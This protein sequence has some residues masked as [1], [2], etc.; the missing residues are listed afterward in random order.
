MSQQKGRSNEPL[1]YRLVIKASAAK[2]LEA[3]GQKTDRL[4]L[5]ACIQ[6]LA[7]QPKPVGVEKL[8]GQL[9]LYR[10]RAGNYRVVYEIDNGHIVVTVI[11][12]GHRKEIYRSF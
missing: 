10:I 12:V 7:T 3:I 1:L 4:R 6:L 9:E 5:V 2:E 8:S 11:K